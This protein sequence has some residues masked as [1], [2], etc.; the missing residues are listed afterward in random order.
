MARDKDGCTPLHEAAVS[1]ASP[2]KS[3]FRESPRGVEVIRALLKHGA[4][5]TA[6]DK[7]GRTP[8]HM[9]VK[10]AVANAFPRGV[11]I[12]RALLEGGGDLNI[13]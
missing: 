12:V 8:L 5:A 9:A 6:Q 7:Y 13:P 4:D 10:S 1:A 11:E 2:S 3:A